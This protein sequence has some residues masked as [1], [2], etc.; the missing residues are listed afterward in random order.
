MLSSRDPAL[1]CSGQRS[2]CQ[3]RLSKGRLT[4]PRV[5]SCP[6]SSARSALFMHHLCCPSEKPC[7]L[8]DAASSCGRG[9]HEWLLLAIC[10]SCTDWPFFKVPHWHGQWLACSWEVILAADAAD[11]SSMV[12]SQPS[13]DTCPAWDNPLLGRSPCCSHWSSPGHT[14]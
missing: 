12:A 11:P 7:E 1:L 5:P 3:L 8:P 13:Q 2:R 10:G 4:V 6:W 9:A 14:L